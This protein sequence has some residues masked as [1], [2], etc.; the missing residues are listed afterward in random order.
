MV[1]AKMRIYIY[2]LLNVGIHIPDGM[3]HKSKATV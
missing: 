3:S 1:G 2:V